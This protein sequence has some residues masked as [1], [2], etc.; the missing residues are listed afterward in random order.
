M[1]TPT[2]V[3]VALGSNLGSSPILVRSALDSLARLAHSGFRASSLWCSSPVDC[4]AGSPAFINA[5]ALFQPHAQATPET[6]LAQLQQLER[7]FGRTPKLVSNEPRPLD[8]D[9]IAFGQAIRQTP[10]LVLPHPR[11]HLRRFV[12]APLAEVAPDWRAPGWPDTASRLLRTLRTDEVV[13][14]LRT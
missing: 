2:L 7:S 3:V 1:L 14:R 10:F 8:L 9:L 5:C 6:L 11:A 12:L 4:P 13:T